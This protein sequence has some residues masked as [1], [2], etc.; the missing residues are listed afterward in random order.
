M[1]QLIVF[2]LFALGGVINYWGAM[3]ASTMLTKNY[4]GQW[5]ERQV[6]GLDLNLMKI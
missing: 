6:C 4:V 2:A 1:I 3:K 5:K